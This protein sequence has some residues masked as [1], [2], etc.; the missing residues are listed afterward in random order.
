[1]VGARARETEVRRPDV[2]DALSVQ[3][4]KFQYKTSLSADEEFFMMLDETFLNSC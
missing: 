4:E 3:M 2:F 1:M